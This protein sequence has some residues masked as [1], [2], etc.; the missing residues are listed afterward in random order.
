[1]HS[2]VAEGRVRLTLVG[3]ISCG[4]RPASLGGSP[5]ST[6]SEEG[7]DSHPASRCSHKARKYELSSRLTRSQA[8]PKQNAHRVWRLLM[9][10]FIYSVLFFTVSIS[11]FNYYIPTCD[12]HPFWKKTNSIFKWLFTTFETFDHF[13]GDCTSSIF[14]PTS[15]H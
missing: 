2:I 9:R 10:N 14:F 1:V 15:R 3:K 11:V 6:A 8:S 4:W 12:Y 7:P 13:R 5:R